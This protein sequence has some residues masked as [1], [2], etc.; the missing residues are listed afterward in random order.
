M[1][2]VR[3]VHTSYF[4]NSAILAYT[5]ME[6]SLYIPR[7]ERELP[8]P[9]SW[10][11]TTGRTSDVS[12]P[13]G[14]ISNLGI[15]WTRR[16]LAVYRIAIA[17]SDWFARDN[18]RRDYNAVILSS[19]WCVSRWDSIPPDALW[20][21]RGSKEVFYTYVD[22]ENL[23]FSNTAFEH[24]HN[25]FE[26]GDV[27]QHGILADQEER[28]WRESCWGF[29]PFKNPHPRGY[30]GMWGRFNFRTSRRYRETL[31]VHDKY[32]SGHILEEGW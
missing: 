25:L 21:V 20:W 16:Q 24:R 11:A 30:Q 28:L 26:S 23:N 13:V 29:V 6:P 10:T 8:S 2:G 1:V 4:L 7:L 18:P 19:D 15:G 3:G 27:S 5:T 22:L 12:G 14:Y 32:S 31:R 9:G 17:P